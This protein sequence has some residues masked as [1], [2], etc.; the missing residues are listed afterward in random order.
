MKWR[1]DTAFCMRAA[2]GGAIAGLLAACASM[3]RPEGGAIDEV[4]PVFV[5]ST[6]EPNALNVEKGRL[7]IYFDENVQIKDAMTKVTV[8]PAQK[9]PPQ[10]QAAA[11]KVTVTLRDTLIPNTT[12]TIDFADAISDLNEGN[13]LDGFSLA[14]STG[15]DI[16]TLCIAGMVFEARNLEPAQGMMVGVYSNPSDTAIHTLPFERLTKT[17]KYGQFTIRN[18]KPGTYRVY[19]LNDQNRDYKWDRTEDI[20][21]YDVSVSPT[22][23]S[24][25]VTDTLTTADGM[26]DSLVNRQATRY[27]P[28]DI[29]LTWWNE[30]YRNQYLKKYERPDRK[31]LNFEFGAIADTLPEIKIVGGKYDGL[32]ISRWAVLKGSKTLDSLEYWISD[33]SIMALDSL[34]LSA[35]FKRTDSLGQLSW[36]I[37]T[38]QL[39]LKGV[40]K[41]KQ[42]EKKKSRDKDKKEGDSI[43]APPVQLTPLQ[44]ASS[45]TQDLNR[46]LAIKTDVPI[47]S[48]DSAGVHMRM[49]VDT[50]WTDVAPPRFI[51]P[52]SLNPMLMTAT[53]TW[54]PGQKYQLVIDSLALTDIYGLHNKDFK[55]ELTTRKLED[56]STINFDLKNVE[57][58]AMVEL[59]N[60][61]DK[62]VETVK[63]NGSRATFTYIQPGNYYARLWI[64]RNDNGVWD[65]GTLDS[66]QPEEVYYLPKK[67]SLKK[68]WDIQQEWDIF[69]VPLDLQKPMDIKKNKPKSKRPDETDNTEEDDEDYYDPTDPFGKRK[70]KRRGTTGNFM[71]NGNGFGGLGNGGRGIQQAILR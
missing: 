60:Q 38:L 46:G 26:R 44:L 57:G 68:N 11:H 15:S 43:T 54:E 70:D 1:I 25:T 33:T 34:K 58:T 9:T 29:L 63:A 6:P 71:Q 69:A 66:I 62:P 59:L 31:R 4:P 65:K 36:G 32:D 55:A 23:T 24:V 12:Y 19:A 21:F 17:N 28:D 8:S 64:D 41:K 14:F 39:N 22:T 7:S 40:K 18:L 30:D 10:V 42:E 47:L 49:M 35:R 16:D 61:Q 52:D 53:Y 67:L 48:L 3:G 37:D 45:N 50:L 5:K 51:R 20:A 27:L 13:E 56:Y 2:L